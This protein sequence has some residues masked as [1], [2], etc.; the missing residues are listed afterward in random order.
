MDKRITLLFAVT[1]LLAACGDLKPK[2]WPFADSGPRERA[3]DPANAQEYACSGDKRFYLRRLDGGAVWLILPERE[4]RLEGLGGT[5][6]GKGSLVLELGTD[7]ASLVDG[8]A[9]SFSG[10][11]P[12]AK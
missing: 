3:R 2:I 5:R 6:Y 4:V 8:A 11:R 10:C 12:A 9:T 1:S 7:V